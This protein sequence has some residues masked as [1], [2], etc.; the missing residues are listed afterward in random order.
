MTPAS[1]QRRMLAALGVSI[2]SL[3]VLTGCGGSDTDEGTNTGPVA[4]VTPAS[5]SSP[6]AEPSA[7]EEPTVDSEAD[8]AAEQAAEEVPEPTT[9][10][11]EAD[12]Q[13]L[14]V[15][16]EIELAPSDPGPRPTLSWVAVDGAELYQVSV[17]DANGRPYW[18]WSG[19]ETEVPLGGMANPDAVGAWVFE[20]LTW[21]VVARDVAGVALAMSQ[22]G[23]L[24]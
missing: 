15:F 7:D 11:G 3:L 24:R 22:R 19:T 6:A 2:L 14:D 18:A 10:A 13:W 1:T 4:T 12:D 21:T 17:L 9:P 20:E 8:D 5:E 23:V 16:P